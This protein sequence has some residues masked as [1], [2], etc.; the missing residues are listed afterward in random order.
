LLQWQERAYFEGLFVL[1]C[2]CHPRYNE[3]CAGYDTQ[4]ISELYVGAALDWRLLGPLL[5]QE[6]ATWKITRCE[7]VLEMPSEWFE[8]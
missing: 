2:S 8:D 4:K 5:H 6:K 3:V 7:Q 1:A